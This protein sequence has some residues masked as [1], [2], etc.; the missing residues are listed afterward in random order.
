MVSPA[1]QNASVALTFTTRDQAS[2][3][4]QRIGGNMQRL[5][6][7]AEG[8]GNVMAKNSTAFLAAG[9]ALSSIGGQVSGLAI[10]F[11]LLSQEQ[12]D[13]VNVGFQVS[14]V[15]LGTVTALAV[16]KTALVASGSSFAAFGATLLPV[17]TI[18]LA[19]VAAILFLTSALQG[20]KD[21][22]QETLIEKIPGL[23]LGG[24][25]GP[26][27]TRGELFFGKTQKLQQDDFASGIR[28][29]IINVGVLVAD[30]TGLRALERKLRGIRGEESRTRGLTN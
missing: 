11:G 6:A 3:G 29:N 2:P 12:G 20:L 13:F 23:E 8:V 7:Q 30:E 9:L 4:I 1:G 24:G 5:Q 15:V 22:T 27:R 25:A 21:P 19:V 28:Q 14:A 16:L 10:R 17:L 26:T 18:A